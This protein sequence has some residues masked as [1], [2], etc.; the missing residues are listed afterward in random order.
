VRHS[1]W[2][3]KERARKRRAF[4]QSFCHTSSCLYRRPKIFNCSKVTRLLPSFVQRSPETRSLGHAV[5]AKCIHRSMRTVSNTAR[6]RDHSRMSG[7]RHVCSPRCAIR[8]RGILITSNRLR[9]TGNQG[10]GRG[11]GVGRARGIGLGR[12]VGVG[13]GV[14]VGVGLVA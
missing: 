6:G 2:R 11:C 8:G 1:F 10:L 14:G 13:L 12:G 4:K 7:T 9:L 5:P 3:G